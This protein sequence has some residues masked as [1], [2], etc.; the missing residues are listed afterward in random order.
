[1][2][3]EQQ[4][5]E[6]HYTNNAFGLA[7]IHKRFIHLFTPIYMTAYQKKEASKSKS[8]FNYTNYISNIYKMKGA[9][10]NVEKLIHINCLFV[11]CFHPE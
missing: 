10:R 9:C 7:K 5:R 6:I 8:L 3:E 2:Y 11:V 4:G 1:M